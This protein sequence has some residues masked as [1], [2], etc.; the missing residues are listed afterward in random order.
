MFCWQRLYAISH[1]GGL[2]A[3]LSCL[4]GRRIL[5][6]HV[7]DAVL[8]FLP[9]APRERGKRHGALRPD[10]IAVTIEENRTEPSEKLASAVVATQ[11]LPRLHQR[12]LSQ[13]FGQARVAAEREGLSPQ[14]CFIKPADTAKRFGVA[15][16]GPVEQTPRV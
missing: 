4:I 9:V 16:L 7:I 11:A 8:A 15:C 2:F 1:Q 5:I 13:I 14:A 10:R 3:K 12:V 6:R